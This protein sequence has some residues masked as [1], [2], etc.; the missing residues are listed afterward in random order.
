TVERG[1]IA[2]SV[3]ATGKVQPLAKVEVKSKASGIVKQIFV[4]YGD[5]VKGGQV[6]V[7]LDKEALRASVREARATL[8]ATQAAQEAAEATYERNVVEAEGPDMPFLKASI[9]RKSTR[10]NSSH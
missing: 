3:V 4:D 1:D 5:R 7:E 10:L 8:Q 9:D 6:L 2:R